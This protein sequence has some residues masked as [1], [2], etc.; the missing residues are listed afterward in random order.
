MTGTEIVL[1]ICLISQL[2]MALVAYVALSYLAKRNGQS[3]KSISCSPSHG[4]TA[5]FSQIPRDTQSGNTTRSVG[6]NRPKGRI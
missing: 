2:P 1:V 6:R 5:E 4:I 3:V